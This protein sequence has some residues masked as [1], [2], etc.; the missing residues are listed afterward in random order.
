[1]N[2]GGKN[3]VVS[4]ASRGLGKA[5]AEHFLAEG[6]NEVVGLSRSPGTVKSLRYSHIQ[7]DVGDPVAVKAAFAAIGH[8]D[9]L[10]NCAGIGTSGVAM[11]MPVADIRATVETNLLGTIYCS[12]EAVRLM[13]HSGG[14]IINIGSIHT[15]LEPI[16]ASAYVASKAGMMAYGAVL[17]KEVASYGITVNTLGLSPFQSDM[18]EALSA[19]KRDLFIRTLTIPRMA[20]NE[21][22]T[23]VVEF[24]ASD[25]S[26]FITGQ[27]IHL[28]GIHE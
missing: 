2:Y 3:L 23:N 11:M 8:L 10:V 26:S 1:M 24:F 25:Q 13:R 16:G 7:V 17:A 4:G 9:V 20:T 15:V 28:G 22:V 19:E 6:A 18:F 21:D 5:L 14:R 27:T 12:R